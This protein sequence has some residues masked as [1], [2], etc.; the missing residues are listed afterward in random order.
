MLPGGDF[1]CILQ[2][3]VHWVLGGDIRV[4]ELVWVRPG[5]DGLHRGLVS[6]SLYSDFF[7][8]ILT[9][10]RQLPFVG[11]FLTLP[12]VRDV[13]GKCLHMLLAR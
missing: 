11:T 13:C 8:V 3:A 10:L 9:F 1:A 5:H 2:M 7:P 4:P 6:D 12:Y